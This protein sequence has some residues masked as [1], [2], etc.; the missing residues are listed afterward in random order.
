[1][2]W[3]ANKHNA[4]Q[5]NHT[6]EPPASAEFLRLLRISEFFF[7][8]NSRNLADFLSH[9]GKWVKLTKFEAEYQ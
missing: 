1:M 8:L 3:L 7:N 2:S 5:S 6:P 9:W 4:D